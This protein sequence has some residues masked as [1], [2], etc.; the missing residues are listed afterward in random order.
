MRLSEHLLTTGA[1]KTRTNYSW[2]QCACKRIY[3]QTGRGVEPLCDKT[4]PAQQKLSLRSG[5][6]PTYKCP[7]ALFPGV[8]TR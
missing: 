8:T 3:V 7:L 2:G 5:E 4:V 6:N 1:L